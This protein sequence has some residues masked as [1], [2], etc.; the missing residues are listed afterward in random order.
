MKTKT[1]KRR[2]TRSWSSSSKNTSRNS[3]DSKRTN[4]CESV[5]SIRDPVKLLCT[6][7]Q[8]EHTTMPDLMLRTIFWSKPSQFSNQPLATWKSI[9]V[10][11][12]RQSAARMTTK[13]FKIEL[14]NTKLENSWIC[15]PKSRQAL[16][17]KSRDSLNLE[18]LA[19]HPQKT[20]QRC[21]KS[22]T[23]L[24]RNKSTYKRTCFS[25]SQAKMLKIFS[26]LSSITNLSE[27]IW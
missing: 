17:T 21:Q 13:K 22:W 26:S 4:I 25:L 19:E 23:F 3:S 16:P 1:R 20:K 2:H 10:T 15:G 11:Y 7:M 5:Y 8:T 6:N 18:P 9:S 12:T 14:A 24:P 27:T